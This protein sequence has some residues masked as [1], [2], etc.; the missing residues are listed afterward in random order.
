MQA[1][2]SRDV[3]EAKRA[4]TMEQIFELM[5]K[6]QRGKKIGDEAQTPVAVSEQACSEPYCSTGHMANVAVDQ[7]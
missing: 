6:K 4:V 1:V 7:G 2:T 5:W 3:E